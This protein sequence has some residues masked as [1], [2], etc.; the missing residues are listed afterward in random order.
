VQSSSA[1][2][3]AIVFFRVVKIG[4]RGKNPSRPVIHLRNI[5]K[6]STESRTRKRGKKEG[7]VQ[8]ITKKPQAADRG[9][10]EEGGEEQEVDSALNSYSRF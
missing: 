4:K 7:R 9:R 6:T 2:K 5:R 8:T 3:S 10:P 1:A